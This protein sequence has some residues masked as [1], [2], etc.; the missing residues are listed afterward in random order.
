VTVAVVALAA[1][2]LSAIAALK[3]YPATLPLGAGIVAVGIFG[4]MLSRKLYERFKY[5]WALTRAF[6]KRIDELCPQAQ[7]MQCMTAAEMEHRVVVSG[8]LAELWLRPHDIV[9]GLGVV[10]CLFA[11]ANIWLL[12]HSGHLMMLPDK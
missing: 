6:E 1:A 12:W 11:L 2:L 5:H 4:R 8:D 3:F 10:C 7:I 9:I